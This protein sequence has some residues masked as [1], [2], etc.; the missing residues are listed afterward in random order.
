MPKQGFWGRFAVIAFAGFGVGS[1][2]SHISY[3]D[4]LP[5]GTGGSFL[6]L[7]N[8]SINQ[9]LSRT[10]LTAGPTLLACLTLFIL[11]GEV[12]NELLL[13]YSLALW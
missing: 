5:A 2:F 10:P 13:R 7:A 6:E 11:G 12:L 4:L 9:T 8:R 1:E 3:T